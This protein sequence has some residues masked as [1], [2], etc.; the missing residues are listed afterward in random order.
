[1]TEA[2]LNQSELGR[3]VNDFL[4]YLQVERGVSPLTLRNYRH[5]LSRLILWMEKE[6]IRENL[7]DIN[8]DVIRAYRV[9][10][11]NLGLGRRTQGYHVIALRSFLKWLI[12][13]DYSVMAPD[14][15][16]L[17]KVE[18]RQVK[19]LNGEQVDRLLNAPSQDSIQG[20]RDKAIL[21]IL[22]STGL[23]VSELVKLNRDKIDMDRR[24]FGIVGK[25]GKARV[26]FLSSRAADWLIK[27]LN[28]RDD[29]F[30]PLFIRH[31]GRI[32]PTT[33]DEKTRLTPRSVQRMI[34]KY[35][36]KMKLPIEVTPHVMRHCIHSE[37]RI[38]L[39]NKIEA[40][41]NLYYKSEENIIG[42]DF[43]LGKQISAKVIGK[44]SH[45]SNLYSLWADGYELVCSNTHRVFTITING[46]KEVLIKDLKTGDYIAGVRKINFPGQKVVDPQVARLIGYVLGDG[47]V[48][49]ER[50]GVIIHDKDR[51]N[52][53]FYQKII[54]NFLKSKAK[55]EKNPRTNS[56]RLN[57]YSEQFV[58][59]LQD[60]GVIGKSKD[61]R[62]PKEIINSTRQ[63]VCGFIAGLYDAEG[64]SFGAPRLFSSS[65]DLLK[66]V[67]MMLLRLGID[68]HLL[69]RDRT[70]KLPQGNDYRHMFYTLQVLGNTDQKAFIKL[71]PTL[72]S[73]TIKA[74]NVQEE[75]KLPV[76]PILKFIFDDLEK[77]GKGGFRRAM[78]VNEN[79]KSSRNLN[80]IVPMRSTVAKFIRQIERFEYK[81]RSLKVLKNIYQA[82]NLKWLKVK[83]IKK[84][85]FNRYNVFDFT[86]SPTR[87]L[88]T[89]GI[90]SHNSF[91]TDLLNAGA[92]IR[93]VQ[94]ML[95]HKNIS[96]TQIYTHV[97]NKQL[98]DIH[99]AFHGH[100]GK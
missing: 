28:H 15:I 40:A 59:F 73:G 94:E 67:Q 21:E 55:I 95:G 64:N 99:A 43:G 11:A 85:P 90:V 44:E 48:S 93:S 98:R 10:L 81:G 80:N 65:K 24:E 1:M 96:T 69:S 8:Q 38:F 30:K 50:R 7:K 84:L 83:K 6:G 36:H 5:Y 91:A 25:G 4:E 26:V 92:D 29:H 41:R 62:V 31:K 17:P 51:K 60:L 89:D 52:L 54:K 49:K 76:Q 78:Q 56:F 70:V 13:N 100:G 45:I 23:R 86:V 42:I 14:K 12:K 37:T 16:D 71:I 57:F 32:D 87:N 72:K 88:I 22:F 75:N 2:A 53:E 74:V 27:Y 82:E 34:K 18:E 35:S 66:D 9:F 79:V 33:P 3:K 63:E 19:F 68:A 46:I 77:N 61:K 39:S 97:T 47:I 58:N 20:K